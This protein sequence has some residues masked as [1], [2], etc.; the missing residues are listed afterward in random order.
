MLRHWFKMYT[1]PY[2]HTYPSVSQKFFSY[3]IIKFTER[4]KCA[5]ES[6]FDNTYQM[7]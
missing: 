2:Y 1:L 3:F 5:M 7:Q 6:V 4:S